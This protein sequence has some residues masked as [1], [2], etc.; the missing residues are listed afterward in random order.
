MEVESVL[1]SLGAVNIT[2]SQA[3]KIISSGVLDPKKKTWNR[4]KVGRK[5]KQLPQVATNRLKGR[6]NL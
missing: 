3:E 2:G 4:S 5:P 6:G 1:D